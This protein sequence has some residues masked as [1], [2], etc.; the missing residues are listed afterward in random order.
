[1]AKARTFSVYLFYKDAFLSAETNLRGSGKEQSWPERQF[2]DGLWQCG[3]L[4]VRV[5]R[6]K[7]PRWRVQFDDGAVKDDIQL[8]NRNAFGRTTQDRTK[9]N[10]KGQFSGFLVV[11]HAKSGHWVQFWSQRRGYD[12]TI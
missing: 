9:S 3:R 12:F 1:M 2:A 6:L 7:L 10:G 11:I 5:A 4:V 8:G